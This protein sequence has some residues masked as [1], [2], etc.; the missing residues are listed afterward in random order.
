MLLITLSLSHWRILASQK[1]TRKLL[2]MIWFSFQDMYKSLLDISFHA[3][4]GYPVL[5]IQTQSELGSAACSFECWKQSSLLM[6]IQQ[7]I[8][9]TDREI[10]FSKCYQTLQKE[11]YVFN[12]S[13][14][15][16]SAAIDLSNVIYLN[17]LKR[18][19][20]CWFL[21]LL[22]WFHDFELAAHAA[23]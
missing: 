13:W 23:V 19:Q 11:T 10:S 7:R 12:S 8:I 17:L 2:E 4:L 16:E 5:I 21:N 14:Q 3:S 18:V 22:I 1:Q 9:Q 6:F 15:Y 20:N